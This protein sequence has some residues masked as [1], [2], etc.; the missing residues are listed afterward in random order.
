MIPKVTKPSRNNRPGIAVRGHSPK[1]PVISQNPAR[2]PLPL[3][4][5]LLIPYL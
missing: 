1:N 4:V 2:S 5:V 3:I